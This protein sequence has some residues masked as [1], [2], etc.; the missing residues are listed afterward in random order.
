MIN[1]QDNTPAGFK[2]GL[3]EFVAI[4]G[5]VFFFQD[6]KM[7]DF[8]FLSIDKLSLIREDMEANFSAMRAFENLGIIDPI[9]MLK[10]YLICNF[11]NFDNRADITPEGI[12]VKEH[13]TCSAR[14]NC[15]YEGIL[16]QHFFPAPNGNLTPREIEIMKMI[17]S[18][19]PDKCIAYKLGIE[20][21]TM[22]THRK[23][24]EQKIGC[25][26]K[27]GITRFACE[28]NIL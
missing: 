12:L 24:I 28:N 16:C 26:T 1:Q 22:A 9:E 20:V 14:G 10:Q 5:E 6:K 21:T 4:D 2:E 3:T 13:V 15:K 27:V 23:H 17:A 19:L 8:R 7:V 25:A 18:D 11:G